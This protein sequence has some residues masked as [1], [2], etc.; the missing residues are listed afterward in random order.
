MENDTLVMERPTTSCPDT[1]DFKRPVPHKNKFNCSDSFMRKFYGHDSYC[2]SNE[3]NRVL[4][5]IERP[6]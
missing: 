2:P 6:Y 4:D 5:K 1:I 3:N